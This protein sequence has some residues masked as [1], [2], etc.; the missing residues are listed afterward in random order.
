M[1]ALIFARDEELRGKT[2]AEG[3]LPDIENDELRPIVFALI[4]EEDTG[5]STLIFSAFQD[6]EEFDGRRSAA[7]ELPRGYGP[8]DAVSVSSHTLPRLAGS[9]EIDQSDVAFKD[10]VD[11]L[12]VTFA[13]VSP[14]AHRERLCDVPRC[15]VKSLH[16]SVRSRNGREKSVVAVL[17]DVELEDLPT[18]RRR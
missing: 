9:L 4:S 15:C 14:P 17:I 12:I 2:F 5:R 10:T 6:V 16:R 3:V 7:G 8:N 18:V 1:V 11:E 13:D